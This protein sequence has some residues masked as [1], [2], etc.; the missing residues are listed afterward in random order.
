[1]CRCGAV[2]L[3]RVG[4]YLIDC[5]SM[6]N[7]LVGRTTVHQW[8]PRQH[9]HCRIAWT[10]WSRFLIKTRSTGLKTSL[11]CKENFGLILKLCG[12]QWFALGLDVFFLFLLSPIAAKW[13]M[14]MKGKVRK[15]GV[16]KSQKLQSCIWK[17]AWFHFVELDCSKRWDRAVKTNSLSF[18]FICIYSNCKVTHDPDVPSIVKQVTGFSFL[19]LKWI[20]RVVAICQCPGLLQYRSRVIW[21]IVGGR[22]TP[23]ETVLEVGDS[24]HSNAI[25]CGQ[26]LK[27]IA[28]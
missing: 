27:S 19:F 17:V 21:R 22:P 15:G 12:L 6:C 18:H 25:N 16:S 26:P 2:T 20:H 9:V 10:T 5:A 13:S 24:S 1:M 11:L 8:W 28:H 3:L 7:Q 4:H 23:N 14:W